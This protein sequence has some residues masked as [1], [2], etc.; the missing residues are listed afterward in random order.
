MARLVN[1]LMLLARMDAGQSAM[2]FKPLDLSQVAD[3]A[4]QRLKVLAQQRGVQVQLAPGVPLPVLGDRQYLLQAISNLAENAIKYS[5][6]GQAVRL[7]T[8]REDGW[9][10]LRVIDTGPGIP[11]RHLPVL[12]DRFYQ[13]DAVRSQNDDDA[14]NS[15]GS[16]LG[17]S[18][19]KSIVQAH[20]GEI[21]VDSVLQ[22]GTTFEV[23]LPLNQQ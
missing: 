17:L 16:G 12:F 8:I 23:R 11:A 7:E 15:Q 22:Q 1:D 4:V 18:I 19:A 10:I 5:G 6:S 14:G 9:A 2:E 3:E 13:V 20:H 21:R